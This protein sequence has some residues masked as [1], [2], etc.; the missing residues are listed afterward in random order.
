MAPAS[1]LRRLLFSLDI[2]QDNALIIFA[3]KRYYYFRD[4]LKTIECYLQN[5]KNRRS[6]IKNLID[7]LN[8][9]QL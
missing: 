2:S 8:L 6:P 9:R 5:V 7:R 4:Q 1:K 3:V